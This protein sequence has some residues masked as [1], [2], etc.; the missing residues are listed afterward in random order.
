[1]SRQSGSSGILTT[2]LGFC[3]LSLSLMPSILENCFIGDLWTYGTTKTREVLVVV[4]VVPYRG[5]RTPE[6]F[7]PIGIE[8]NSAVAWNRFREAHFVTTGKRVP[9]TGAPAAR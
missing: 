8:T 1:M 9:R 7:R 2:F 6:E 5:P 3:C 4:G